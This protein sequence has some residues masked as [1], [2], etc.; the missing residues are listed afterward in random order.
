MGRESL[1]QKVGESDVEKYRVRD[2]PEV[3]IQFVS[4]D[5]LKR[6]GGFLD[7]ERLPFSLYGGE[8]IGVYQPV[9]DYL[10]A[11][12]FNFKDIQIRHRRYL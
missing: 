11:N 1:T 4:L 6:A 8:I 3:A 7:K 5:E 2:E 9:R 12:G 10:A